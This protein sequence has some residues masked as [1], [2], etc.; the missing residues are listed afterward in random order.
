[1]PVESVLTAHTQ[2]A[3]RSTFVNPV[4]AEDFPDP[5]ILRVGKLYYAYATNADGVELPLRTSR[6]LLTWTEPRDAMGELPSWAE[7]GLTWAPDVMPVAGGFVLYYTVRH[8]ASA[9]QV[10]GAAFSERPEGPFVDTLGA[11]FIAQHDLGGAIDAHAFVDADGTRY[12]YWKN[13]GNS[14]GQRTFLWVQ[15]LSDDGLALLGE[16]TALLCNDQAWEGNLIEAPFVSVHGGLY[17]LFY[18]AAHYG[19]ATYGVG[20]AVAPSPLGPFVKAEGGPIL[21]S[22]GEVAGPGGQG[23]LRDDAGHTWMYYHAWTHGLVGYD[24]GGAR[25]LR[26]DPLWWSESGPFLL[27]GSVGEQPAPVMSSLALG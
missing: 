1:M 5:F 15:R 12:L 22:A 3:P 13:D 20:Y 2:E 4:I 18:S 25:S 10:I 16:P 7:R 8:T 27:G 14:C 11:P 19:D 23:V 9:Q 21:R 17:Y 26:L 6:D 24:L